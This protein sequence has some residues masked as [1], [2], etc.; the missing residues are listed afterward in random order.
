MILL[1][2]AVLHKGGAMHLAGRQF[3]D[4]GWGIA[5]AKLKKRP[6]DAP[7]FPNQ[8]AIQPSRIRDSG[9]PPFNALGFTGQ[10]A[11]CRGMNQ[12]I[13]VFTALPIRSLDALSLQ[14]RLTDIGR[15]VGATAK[16]AD[17]A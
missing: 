15:M 10:R 7:K 2:G 6:I 8:N 5:P 14:Q 13:A 12:R 11:D 16:A 9:A 1:V 4:L 17:P 3:A